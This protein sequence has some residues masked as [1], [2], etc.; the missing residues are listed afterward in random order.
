MK[1]LRSHFYITIFL[2]FVIFIQPLFAGT[3]PTLVGEAA[4]LMESST[5]T[6]LYQKN[7]NI[8]M[9]P[10]STT[11]ILSSI[12]YIENLDPKMPLSKTMESIYNVPPNSSHIGLKAGDTFSVLDGVYAVMLGSDNYVAYDLAIKLDGS[13]ENF[14]N[15]MNRKAKEI[16]AK[17]SNFVNPH[18][19]HDPNHY[20]TAYDLAL[21]ASY[22]FDNYTFREIAKSPVHTLTKLNDPS[23]TIEFLHTVKL[24]QPDSPYY[25]PYSL[26]GKTGFTTPAGRSLV[27][28]AKKDGMELIGVVLKSKSPEFFED[29]N[30]LFEYGFENFTLEKENNNTYLRNISFSPW[31]EDIISFAI[32][33]SLIDSFST[34]SYQD[35]ISTKD[36]I[37]LLARTVAV[38]HSQAPDELSNTD[39]LNYA[40]EHNLIASSSILS[41]INEPINRQ[42]AAVLLYEFLDSLNYKP[43][44]IYPYNVYDDND[45]ISI[46]ALNSIY[47]LQK[48]GLLG[49]YKDGNFNPEKNLTLEEAISISTKLYKI[50][51]NS[52][53]AKL[54][55]RLVIFD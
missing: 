10:A 8:Q 11:K 19:Y 30:A 23:T 25:Y 22:A 47:F 14:A 55:K 18:G 52:L 40:L 12:L 3:P 34:K 5:G 32:D 1:N 35:Y 16:G 21:I 7:S 49:S 26:G 2:S 50:Y 43:Y 9:Y 31:A 28:V 46:D 24:L 38:A 54:N 13:I 37:R 53:E 15:R 6:V 36:F 17:N 51:S 20:T 33:N 48:S 45:S 44:E 41:G 4:L 42:N 39:A 27:A 29:M